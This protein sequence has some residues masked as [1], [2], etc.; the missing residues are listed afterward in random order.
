[1]WIFLKDAFFSIVT[2]PKNDRLL[3]VR[4]RV[5]GDIERVFS[6]AKVYP[7]P[8]RDYAFR[9]FIPRHVVARAIA[10]EVMTI[11]ATNF[12][13]SVKEDFRHDAYMRVWGAALSLQ[14]RPLL[15]RD[16]RTRPLFSGPY[17]IDEDDDTKDGAEMPAWIPHRMRA[18]AGQ[19]DDL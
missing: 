8:D 6:R 2:C 4:A 10:H 15:R 13:A 19:E 12:K 16:A 7:T 18:G 5:P 1:M 11:D 9:A 3:T 17:A 14:E